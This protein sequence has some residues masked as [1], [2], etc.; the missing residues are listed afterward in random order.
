VS[1]VLITLAALVLWAST[2]SGQPDAH[3]ARGQA[4]YKK[5][6]FQAAIEAF[7][8]V[9]R[10]APHPAAL[11]SIARCHENLGRP[12]RA[13][14]FYRR[15]LAIEKDPARRRNIE[16]RM[17]AIR[18][19][20]VR[21]FISTRPSGATVTIDGRAR[22]EPGTTPL[23]A[24]LVP[25]EH[26]L[27]AR[28]EGHD[29]AA[30]R[31]VVELGK[32]QPVELALEPRPKVT[33]PRPCPEPRS[34]PR[35]A[36]ALPDDGG[37]HLMLSAVASTIITSS[38][39]FA[40]GPGLLARGRYGRMLLGMRLEYP[41]RMITKI[42]VKDGDNRWESNSAGGLIAT[43]E[44]GYLIP[45]RTAYAYL[46]AGAGLVYDTQ[47]F[48]GEDQDGDIEHVEGDALFIWS[49][50][51]G[52]EAM[53]TGWLS[54]GASARLGFQH[55]ERVADHDPTELEEGTAT[56]YAAFAAVLTLHL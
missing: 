36:R 54:I 48:R 41:L 34:A 30:R 28:L 49:I 39:Q 21:V 46:V 45:L 31:V 20:P 47:R 29:L 10:T 42:A 14:E 11:F 3:Y 52:I 51:G 38:R 4:L 22:P 17:E 55:G 56:P 18:S 8:E 1:R 6:Q 53:V 19:R 40:A 25:G 7:E 23:T 27:I 9:Q 32:E 50:G 44:G 24:R 16:Q 37:L 2:A 13:L 43:A 26:V 15:A 5:G 33:P 35:P 12:D